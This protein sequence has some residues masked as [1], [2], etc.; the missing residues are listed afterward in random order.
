[1]DYFFYDRTYF[2]FILPAL[3]LSLA[4]QLQVQSA[5]RKYSQI[6]NRRNLTGAEAARQV[7]RFHEITDVPIQPIGGQLTDHYDPRNNSISL[8]SRFMA[9]PPFLRSAWRPMRQDM[10]CSMRTAI[11]QSN[12]GR[13]S[14][15]P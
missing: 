3:I 12:C 9:A 11:S 15:P 13:F 1:M 2:I 6:P 10:R 14:F 5:F 4:A 8:S 7:L